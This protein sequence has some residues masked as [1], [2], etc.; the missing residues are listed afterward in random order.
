MLRRTFSGPLHRGDVVVFHLPAAPN[1]AYIKRLIGM[2]GD[3]VQMKDGRVYLNDR[4]LA[5][6]SL[7]TAQGELP[8]GSSPVRR[9]REATPEGRSYSIQ[10][11][12]GPEMTG[13]TGVYVVPPDCYF[14]LGDNRDNSLDSRFDPGLAPND[15][16]LGG[17]GWNAVLDA[18]VG[19]QPGVGFVPDVA[20]LGVVVWDAAGTRHG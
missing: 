2:P 20:V 13:N 4:P 1:V 9:F 15:P 17:C 19:D 3:H 14:T 18:Q 5:E 11:S 8:G 12:P 10:T 16:R 6:T 7:G